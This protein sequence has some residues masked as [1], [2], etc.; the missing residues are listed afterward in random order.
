MTY[1]IGRTRIQVPESYFSVN[2]WTL[3]SMNRP[4]FGPTATRI[5]TDTLFEGRFDWLSLHRLLND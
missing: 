1:T 5:A 4:E 2:H 3:A